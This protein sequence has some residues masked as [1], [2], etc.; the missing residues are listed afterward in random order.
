MGSTAGSASHG[1][2][3][4]ALSLL[5]RVLV[6]RCFCAKPSA[7]CLWFVFA[8]VLPPPDTR[9]APSWRPR[10]LLPHSYSPTHPSAG[11]TF[12]RHRQGFLHRRQS[13]GATRIPANGAHVHGLAAGMPG[14]VPPA[15]LCGG[16]VRARARLRRS[17][18]V[19]EQGRSPPGLSWRSQHGRFGCPEVLRGRTRQISVVG[20]V[21]PVVGVTVWVVEVVQTQEQVGGAQRVRRRPG[22]MPAVLHGTGPAKP[23]G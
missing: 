5:A 7:R 15:R 8:R 6:S 22:Q 13:N 1:R 21:L 2:C 10:L 14:A 4:H 18:R 11:A 19:D 17:A 9:P 3:V 12:R 16:A 20:Q 23:C